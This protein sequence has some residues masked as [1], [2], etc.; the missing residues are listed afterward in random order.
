MAVVTGAL[1]LASA[2]GD[3][4]GT[5]PP[6]NLAPVANFTVTPPSCTVN[7]PCTFTSTSTDDVGITAYGWD[8]TGDG[9]PDYTT[10]S[11]V[12]TFQVAGTF[13][14]TL[15]VTDAGG[16]TGT[17]SNP[18]TVTATPPVNAAPVANFTPPSCTVGVACNFTDAS[19]DDVAVMGWSW[20][21]NGDGTADAN[22]KDFA[23]TYTAAGTFNAKL[24][25]TDGGTPPLSD[26]VTQ[27]VTVSPPASVLCSPTTPTG[28]GR[29]RVN[30]NLAVT[31]R[32]TLMF[33]VTSRD[34]EIG[35]N[36]FEISQ[37]IQNLVFGNLCSQPV[38]AQFTTGVFEAGTQVQTR[39]TQGTGIDVGD[40]IPGLPEIR[41]EGAFPEWTLRIDDGGAPDQPRSDDIVLTVTATLVQ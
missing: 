16:L 9:T 32:A 41:L 20:D 8:V 10:A 19:T 22:T 14:V 34:C 27:T 31:Q 30:C 3:G 13:P 4:G 25:V 35:G 18:V 36:K 1:V 12:H 29:P 11:A 7:A 28:D 21:F 15:T 39:F 40:P 38:G 23:Y 26:D 2:C 5:P 33:T 37:P 17:K 6:D 24:T